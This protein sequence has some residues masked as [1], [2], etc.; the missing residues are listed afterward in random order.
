MLAA[1]PHDKPA[2]NTGFGV[3]FDTTRLQAMAAY[4]LWGGA[5]VVQIFS[6]LALVS[7]IT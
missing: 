7:L 3:H 2:N 1:R 5:V 4:M 6:L